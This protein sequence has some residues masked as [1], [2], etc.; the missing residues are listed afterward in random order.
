MGILAGL[1]SILPGVIDG[2]ERIFGA[3]KGPEK[4]SAVMAMVEPALKV[5]EIVA[6]KDLYDEAELAEGIRLLIRGFVKVKNATGGY[7]RSA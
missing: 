6:N 5:P 4:E 7:Q 3:K 1:L 2:A